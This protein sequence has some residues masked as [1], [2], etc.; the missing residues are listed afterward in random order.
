MSYSNN[1]GVW[2]VLSPLKTKAP[3]DMMKHH[4]LDYWQMGMQ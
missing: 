2:Y 4:S 3:R 1:L